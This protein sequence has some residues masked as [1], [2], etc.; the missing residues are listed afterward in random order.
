[1]EHFLPIFGEN[2]NIDPPESAEGAILLLPRRK[3]QKKSGEKQKSGKS[4]F[5]LHPRNFAA[6]V[7]NPDQ[8]S[9]QQHFFPPDFFHSRALCRVPEEI[10]ILS[11]RQ[12]CQIFLGTMYQNGEK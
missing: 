6:S 12:G 2:R 3:Q 8:K 1:L 7:G 5:F 10:R 4:D 9:G 11:F